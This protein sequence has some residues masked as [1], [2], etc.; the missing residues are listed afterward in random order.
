MTRMQA[1]EYHL[2]PIMSTLEVTIS[3]FIQ[4]KVDT[5]YD[6]TTSVTEWLKCGALY[7]NM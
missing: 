6:G 7:Q 2:S 5:T 1:P 4:I 3:N